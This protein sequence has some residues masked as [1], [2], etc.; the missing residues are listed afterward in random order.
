MQSPSGNSVPGYGVCE[1]PYGWT[2]GTEC[3]LY[4]E[5]NLF[6]ERDELYDLK[7]IQYLTSLLA[8]KLPD[9]DRTTRS[10]DRD[11]AGRTQKQLQTSCR[12]FLILQK[13]WYDMGINPNYE[14]KISF[15]ALIL[16]PWNNLVDRYAMFLGVSEFSVRKDWNEVTW[17]MVEMKAFLREACISFP[18]IRRTRRLEIGNLLEIGNNYITTGETIAGTTLTRGIQTLDVSCFL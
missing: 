9:T 2:P 4:D 6:R 7:E 1:F 17:L 8:K 18:T 5:F 15:V 12:Y 16:S 14:K 3:H 11:A 13:Q 10:Q